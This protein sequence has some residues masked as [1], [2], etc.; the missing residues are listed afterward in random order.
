LRSNLNLVAQLSELRALKGF[1]LKGEQQQF[2]LQTTLLRREQHD[3]RSRRTIEKFLGLRFQLPPL[4]RKIYEQ[5][6]TIRLQAFEVIV[7]RQ[8]I[9]EV[10]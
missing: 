7:W 4:N 6:S 1:F 2:T 9:L 10:S 3:Q 5:L 8:T